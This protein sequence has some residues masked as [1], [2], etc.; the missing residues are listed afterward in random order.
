MP[1]AQF[2]HVVEAVVFAYV[3][4]EHEG[5][6]V[7]PLPDWKVPTLQFVHVVDAV[8]AANVPGEQDGHEVVP[9]VGWKV[10]APQFVHVVAA[11]VDVWYLYVEREARQDVVFDRPQRTIRRGDEAK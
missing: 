6:D 1:A 2:V 10:P 5:H 4:G 9:L 11:V 3:P 8:A 7:P